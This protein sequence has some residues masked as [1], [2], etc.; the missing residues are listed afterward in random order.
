MN[1]HIHTVLPSPA[2]PATAPQPSVSDRVSQRAALGRGVA[3]GLQPLLDVLLTAGVTVA[4][5]ILA[6]HLTTGLDFFARRA[7]TM[8]IAAVGLIATISV[9]AVTCRRTL[10]R[11][12]R[13]Q[14][15]GENTRALGALLAL[16]LTAIV[17][18][19]PVILA[20]L[21]PQHPAP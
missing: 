10:R 17:V 11:V 9:Y 5:T 21:L 20:V 4:L 1:A 8:S 14:E 15:E 6:W 13:W 2:S 12:A 3:R 19:L 18:A 16:S 7:I